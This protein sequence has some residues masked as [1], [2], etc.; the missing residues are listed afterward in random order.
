MNI[1]IV[2]AFIA[3]RKMV[4]QYADVLKAV[5]GLK[6]RIDGHDAQLNQIY[7]ALE[8]MLDKKAGEEYRQ[9]EWDERE[10]IGFKK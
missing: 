6:E 9:K 8:N 4:I 1:A 10:R 5:D 2:K 7:D 3:M